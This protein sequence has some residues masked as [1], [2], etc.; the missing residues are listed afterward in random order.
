MASL[1]AAI[2]A[3]VSG[4]SHLREAPDNEIGLPQPSRGPRSRRSALPDLFDSRGV[5][6][7]GHGVALRGKRLCRIPPG[8]RCPGRR[9]P[10]LAGYRTAPIYPPSLAVHAASVLPSRPGSF[11]G[12]P[13]EVLRWHPARGCVGLISPSPGSTLRPGGP[14]TRRQRDHSMKSGWRSPT[15]R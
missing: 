11:G 5:C 15:Q 14:G 4:R 12:A 8:P 2:P 1:P 13:S 10:H 7:G 3:E 9:T 6:R